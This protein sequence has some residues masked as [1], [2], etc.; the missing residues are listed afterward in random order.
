LNRITSAL[1][2][3]IERI[4]RERMLEVRDRI[5]KKIMERLRP[6]DLFYQIL[7]GLRTLTR[8]DHS[9][10]LL[11]RD[12]DGAGLVLVAEQIAWTKGKSSK[13]GLKLP[14][15]ENVRGVLASGEVLGFDR[16]GDLWQE[17]EGRPVASLARL[18]DFNRPEADSSSP[19]AA[20]QPSGLDPG[21]GARGLRESAMLVAPVTTR[22]GIFGLLKIAGQHSGIFGPYEA[23][24]VERFRS[25]A[26]IAIENSQRTLSL[27]TRMIE[28]EKKNAMAD[29]ARGVSHDVNNALGAVLPIVQEMREDVRAGR[30]EPQVLL[31]DLE[32]IHTSLEVCRRIFGGML[33]FAR[34]GSRRSSQADVRLA[35][36]ATLAVLKDGLDRRG[37]RIEM[38]LPNNGPFVAGGQS[39]LEQV[40]LNLLTNAR[41]AM[42]QG[43]RLSISV[44]AGSDTVDI[45]IEDTGIGIPSENLPRIQ[46]PFF[47]TKP[48]GTGLGLAICRSILWEMEGKMHIE[49]QSG[50]G[51]R[52]RLILPRGGG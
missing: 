23:E 32:Q 13:I 33:A 11:I 45:T 6:K 1:G 2:E 44:H 26:S 28:A 43:G 40:F 12:D 18:L 22:D 29:L 20:S 38:N 9:S 16:A 36:D 37:V 42:S 31:A 3:S 47:T 30:V 27:H 52:V 21:E 14:L 34:G 25:Q 10:G 17:W 51:T 41:E 46:E 50:Q 5:D 48:H 4:D 24:L 7:D 39:N 19:A 15:T 49:S 35:L 8:Y